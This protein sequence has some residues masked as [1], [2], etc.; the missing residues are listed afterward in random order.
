MKSVARC[1]SGGVSVAL[2]SD[3]GLREQ[4]VFCSLQHI[5][6]IETVAAA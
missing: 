5:A 2:G 1:F 3:D 4:A 6:V